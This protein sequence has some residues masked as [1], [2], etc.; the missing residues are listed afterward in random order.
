MYPVIYY[1]AIV[2]SAM[3]PFMPS[4]RLAAIGEK[5]ESFLHE[6]KSELCKVEPQPP[7]GAR[8]SRRLS[9]GS[10]LTD[11]LVTLEKPAGSE[12]RKGNPP[13]LPPSFGC[14]QRPA[15]RKLRQ[16]GSIS[17]GRMEII[18]MRKT[19]STFIGFHRF[20]SFA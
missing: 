17:V 19:S 7:L 13:S 11:R 2:A 15:V 1:N 9:L 18:C 16:K 12:V 6:P 4:R 3:D 14:K 8:A 5:N 20:P 10:A